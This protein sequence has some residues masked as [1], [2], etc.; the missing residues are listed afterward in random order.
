MNLNNGNPKKN[1]EQIEILKKSERNY[2][3]TDEESEIVKRF[4]TENKNHKHILDFDNDDIEWDI[5]ILDKL[6]STK[7]QLKWFIF[8]YYLSIK[9]ILI[10]K[11]NGAKSI[12]E[13]DKLYINSSIDNQ[14]RNIEELENEWEVKQEK[15]LNEALLLSE[16]IKSGEI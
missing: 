6:E 8:E 1:N 13:F 15:D 7:E 16:K 2:F 3:L 9:A 10:M 5:K 14:S 4:I 11:R 12:D